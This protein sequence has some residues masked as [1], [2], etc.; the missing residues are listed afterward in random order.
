MTPE[1]EQLEALRVLAGATPHLCGHIADGELVLF[2]C[3]CCFR[4]LCDSCATEGC[5]GRTPALSLQAEMGGGEGYE[6]YYALTHE[7]L[8]DELAADV[9]PTLQ[10]R[11]GR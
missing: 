2:Q 1:W 4:A 6:D 3:A 8:V 5:C 7:I 10:R 11:G 9:D